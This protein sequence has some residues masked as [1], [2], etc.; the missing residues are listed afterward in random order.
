MGT[1]QVYAYGATDSI[2]DLS[3]TPV[4][5]SGNESYQSETM[6]YNFR[7][8]DL[9]I[10]IHFLPAY[11]R[12]GDLGRISDGGYITNV[13]TQQGEGY[14]TGGQS[15]KMD[16]GEFYIKDGRYTT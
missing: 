7:E 15:K 11:P 10:Q 6:S 8:N 13:I 1:S 12:C 16:N 14:L 5:K 3:D 4:F 9:M 2:G